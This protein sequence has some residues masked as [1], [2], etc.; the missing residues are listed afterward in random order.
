LGWALSRDLEDYDNLIYPAVAR[1]DEE[2]LFDTQDGSCYTREGMSTLIKT[3]MQK[4]RV[5]GHYGPHK[6][7]HT[8]AT[9]YLR[10]GGQLEQLRIVMGH[11]DISTTQRYLSLMPEDL[12]KAQLS[13]NPYDRARERI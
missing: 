8:Y 10:N 12:Y 6:L 11:R 5:E 9:N 13:A 3:K 7:R 2:A 4:V 1:E